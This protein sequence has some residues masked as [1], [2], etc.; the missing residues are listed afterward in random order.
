M[1]P[2][3]CFPRVPSPVVGAVAMELDFVAVWESSLLLVVLLAAVV[4]HMHFAVAAHI[5]LGEA[6][7]YIQLAGV[8]VGVLRSDSRDFHRLW[9]CVLHLRI[10][11]MSRV[12]TAADS[13]DYP[14]CSWA[15]AIWVC[16]LLALVDPIAP[17]VAATD[18][19]V[20]DGS[21]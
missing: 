5:C 17:L 7:G 14:G 4:M 6:A 18:L 3:L 1:R 10:S 9:P 13:V 16:S 11:S 19:L 8:A 21:E 2:A 12:R 20:F 15:L